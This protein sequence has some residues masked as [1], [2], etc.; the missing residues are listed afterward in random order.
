MNTLGKAALAT[1]TAANT[2]LAVTCAYFAAN[3][4]RNPGAR[5]EPTA[6]LWL[7]AFCAFLVWT[8]HVG[9]LVGAY[10]RRTSDSFKLAHTLG[11]QATPALLG[12]MAAF[13]MLYWRP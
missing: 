9:A 4:L 8:G 1:V 6:L 10:R 5:S 13:L 12:L 2:F 7:M 11:M 3:I